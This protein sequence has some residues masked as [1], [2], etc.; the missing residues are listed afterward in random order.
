MAK[1]TAQKPSKK[2][3]V[4][5]KTPRTSSTATAVPVMATTRLSRFMPWLL[6]VGGAIGIVCS[7]VITLDKMKL[8]E[9]PSFRP[10]CDLNPI[11][12]CGSVMSSA[13]GSAFGFPN[14]WI[15]LAAFAV[16]VTIGVGLLAGA[17]YKRWF[18]LGLLAGSVFG[19]VFVHW[20]F[21]QS[22]YRI[23]A[24]C[25]YCMGVWAVTI[26]TFWYTLLYN[27][28]KGFLAI[29]GTYGARIMTG[30]RRHHLDILL[31]WFIIIAFF[32][33]K[34]FWYFFGKNL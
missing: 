32:I 24:L 19:V 5:A 6:I 22:V 2:A 18:W 15:G 16:L 9:N 4:A 23:Q 20:L 3:T 27:F 26:A 17:S 30:L 8:L 14:P 33:F 29:P 31:L 13:Q 34:H 7:F 12:S 21:Y 28:E 10:N 1:K 25:P 11:I